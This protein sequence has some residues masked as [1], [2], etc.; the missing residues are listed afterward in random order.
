MVLAPGM[1]PVSRL[2]QKMQRLPPKL[3]RKVVPGGQGHG[4]QGLV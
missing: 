4:V 2:V 1:D 3:Y